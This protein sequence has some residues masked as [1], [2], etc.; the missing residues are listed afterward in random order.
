MPSVTASGGANGV[1]ELHDVFGKRQKDIRIHV[2]VARIGVFPV[3]PWL[4]DQPTVQSTDLLFAACLLVY[5]ALGVYAL[6]L[7]RLYV[8]HQ[9]SRAA[10][11]GAVPPGYQL[12]PTLQP[13]V[14]RRAALHFRS[15]SVVV[16]CSGLVLSVFLFVLFPRDV[17]RALFSTLPTDLVRYSTGFSDEVNLTSGTRITD[18]QRVVLNL[19]L[20]DRAP[21]DADVPLLLR[22]TVLERY[23]GDGRWTANPRPKVRMIE[24]R[25]P[26]FTTLGPPEPVGTV[27]QEFELF[28]PSVAMFSVYTPV[29]ISLPQVRPIKFDPHGQTLRDVG[30]RPLQRYTIRAD[31]D[32]SDATLE[33][34]AGGASRTEWTPTKQFEGFNL[35]VRELSRSVLESEGVETAAPPDAAGRWRWNA[36]AAGVLSRYLQGDRYEYVTDLSG[37]RLNAGGDPIVQFLFQ[38]RRGHCEYFASGLAALCNCLGI[39]ARLVTGY[40]ALEFDDRSDRY[41]VRES[42]AHAWVEVQVGPR[43]WATF[44]PTPPSAIRRIHGAGRTLTDRW[45]WMF[46]RFEAKWLTNVVAFDRHAQARLIGTLDFGWSEWIVDTADRIG[47]WLARVNRA[48]YFGPAGYIWMGIVALA[49]I[50]AVIALGTR[51]RR[52]ARVRISLHLG[53]GRAYQ[54]MGRQLGFYL[55]MLTRLESLGKPKPAWQPPLQYADALARRD[56][57]IASV[58]RDITRLF[59]AARYGGRQ[60]TRDELDAASLLVDK[61]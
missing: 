13:T 57:D 24:V 47:Q 31:P 22:G 35:R 56:A 61:M 46:D 52:A 12:I 49:V 50:V 5:A 40:V 19:R 44:D 32:P 10:R 7:F 21:A 36:R 45:Q 16:V 29:S 37:I 55:D 9:R 33:A 59:Y 54:R 51:L 11:L 3:V 2:Q 15:L 60:L 41:I 53:H 14:G 38:T 25:P 34:L 18:S 23:E 8:S 4:R 58:V 43:R 1:S 30:G 6:L 48:F 26:G 17:G 28:A 42:N 27:T 39:P 20:P